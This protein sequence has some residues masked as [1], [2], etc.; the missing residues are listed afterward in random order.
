VVPVAD[1]LGQSLIAV[2]NPADGKLPLQLRWVPSSRAALVTGRVYNLAGEL[3]YQKAVDA[4][5]AAMD[6]SLRSPNGSPITD[7]I[8]V[9]DVEVRDSN[10]R[11]IERLRKKVAV[12][13]R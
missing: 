12:L 4:S 7:G 6:W 5:A 10:N 9:W 2:P 11:V 8:Y 1:Q 3:V 13:H